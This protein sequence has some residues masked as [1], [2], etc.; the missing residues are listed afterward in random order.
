MSDQQN[1][2]PITN[3]IVPE[4]TAGKGWDGLPGVP[5]PDKWP[6]SYGL[7]EATAIA[8]VPERVLIFWELASII[9]AGIDTDLTFRLLR[10]RLNGEEPVHEKDWPVKAIGRFQDS[11]LEPGTEYIWVIARIDEDEQIPLLVTNPVRMPIRATPSGIPDNLPSSIDLLIK[12]RGKTQM[13][14]AG[15][16]D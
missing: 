14:R 9:S 12:S 8:I 15:N 7:D 2:N 16:N 10:M 5:E 4:E 1:E 11:G 6:S 3:D 13:R